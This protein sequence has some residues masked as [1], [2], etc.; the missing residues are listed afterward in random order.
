[1]TAVWHLKK[2]NTSQYRIK[3]SNILICKEL[4]VKI[5]QGVAALVING[6]SF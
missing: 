1:M 6:L 4:T 5:K 3:I 2:E